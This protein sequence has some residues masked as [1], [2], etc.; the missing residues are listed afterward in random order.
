MVGYMS[1]LE[2]DRWARVHNM[3]FM[4]ENHSHRCL[5]INILRELA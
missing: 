5:I 4:M 3:F 1:I 2:M